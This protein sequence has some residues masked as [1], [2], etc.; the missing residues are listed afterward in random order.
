MTTTYT[1][2]MLVGE[3][4]ATLFADG[5]TAQSPD[6]E[7]VEFVD[8]RIDALLGELSAR[9]IVTVSD[10]EDIDVAIFMPLAELLADYCAPKFGQQR[11]KTKREDAEDRVQTA[12]TRSDVDQFKLKTDPA[13]SRRRVG[14]TVAR[15]T[16][17][18]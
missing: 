2:A 8:S 5:G 17:D 18:L 13:L 3:A 14:Y 10:P 16:R 11:D 15:W 7:D 6:P 9:A 12:T 1:R 4:L